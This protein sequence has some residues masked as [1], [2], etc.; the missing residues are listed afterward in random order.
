MVV[1]LVAYSCGGSHG[2]NRVPVSPVRAPSQEHH[3][4][5]REA[6]QGEPL[7]RPRLG[8]WSSMNEGAP[9]HLTLVLGGAR[10]GKSR[11]AEDLVAALPPPWHYVATAQAY[12]EEMR[13][14]I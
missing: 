6:G 9:S 11:H 12:D 4:L 3:G 2:L 10:S 7:R 5:H 8:L 1:R 14:R 13:E